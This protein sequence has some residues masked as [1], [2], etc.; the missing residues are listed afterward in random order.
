MAL[1]CL[2]EGNA[3]PRRATVPIAPV[4]MSAGELLEYDAHHHR[5]ELVHGQLMVREPAGGDHA[6]VLIQVVPP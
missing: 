1:P 3:S 5:T 4:S 2:P 6:A